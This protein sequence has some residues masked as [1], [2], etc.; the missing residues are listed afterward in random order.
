MY[1]VLLGVDTDEQRARAQAEAVRS[2]PAA[3]TAVEALVMHVFQENPEGAS[4]GQ[5]GAVS[6]VTDVF[7]EAG[8]DYEL[9]E[10]SGDP[11]EA[12]LNA[13]VDHDADTI[14]VAGR[15]RTP[16]GKVIFGSTTQSVILGTE[17]PVL[18]VSASE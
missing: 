8:V 15:Q 6:R 18:A 2:L 3:E 17:K 7:K 11:A 9:H 1:R 5:I 14:C 4:V 12:L 16:A 10:M 13:A